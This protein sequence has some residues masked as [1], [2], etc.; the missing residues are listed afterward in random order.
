MILE[1][2][3]SRRFHKARRKTVIFD[4]GRRRH[5]C[6][7]RATVTTGKPTTFINCVKIKIFETRKN[8]SKTIFTE[9]LRLRDRLLKSV[10]AEA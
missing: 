8:L 10:F 3:Q 7:V 2:S 5:Y 6:L 9:R 1:V 4:G